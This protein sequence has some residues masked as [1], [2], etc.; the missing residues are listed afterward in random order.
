MKKIFLLLVVIVCTSFVDWPCHSLG[1]RGPCTHRCHAYDTGPCT[2]SD[3]WGYRV[4]DFDY[5]P[6][7]HR[8]H[9][10]DVY[11]CTHECH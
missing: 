1:D 5:Y 4:H 6:C 8:V 9:D 10:Y 7:G 2:H 11:P 3:W